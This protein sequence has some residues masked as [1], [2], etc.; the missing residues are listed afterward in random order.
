VR[1]T[2]P[3]RAAEGRPPPGRVAAALAAREL[4]PT[5]GRYLLVLALFTLGNASDA[6]LLLRAQRLG[7]PEAALPLLWAAF[8]VSKMSWSVPGGALADRAGPRRAIAGG[9]L[10]YAAVYAAFAFATRTWHVWALFLVYGLFYGLTESPE[11]ALVA[12][13]A[14]ADRRGLAFGAYHLVIGVAALPASVIFGVLWD[15]F[16]PE[17]PFLVGAALSLTAAAALPLAIPG[18]PTVE[19]GL[20]RR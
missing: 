14:P 6:F 11:K 15:A 19:H 3:E 2:P 1:E 12:N 20:D 17:V 13:L 9:W 4:G 10:V 5:F 18:G 16:G 8:H 7:V